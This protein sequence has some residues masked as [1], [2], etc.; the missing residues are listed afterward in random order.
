M[1]GS[2]TTYTERGVLSHT[3]AIAPL[4]APA[5][6]YLGLCLSAPA[7]TRSTGGTEVSGG[8]YVRMAT[9]FALAAN[10]DNMAANS[11]TTEFPAATGLWGT[12]GYFEVW[13][14]ATAG[15]RLFWGPLVDPV[16]GVTPITRAVS[17]GDIVRF[18]AGVVQVTAT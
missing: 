5:G 18:T 9:V 11:A 12:L 13:D 17:V 4:D 14:A 7:P 1:A 8:G 15:N 6:V 10:P 16:D 2:A 3:L